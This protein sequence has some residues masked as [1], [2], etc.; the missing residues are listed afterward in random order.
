[1][2]ADLA[3]AQPAAEA[4]PVS[5]PTSFVPVAEIP[6]RAQAMNARLRELD[7]EVE[8]TPLETHVLEELARLAK[9]IEP[10]VGPIMDNLAS[11]PALA[12]LEHWHQRWKKLARQLTSLESQLSARA[13]MLDAEARRLGESAQLWTR[14]RDIARA[15]GAPDG[16]LEDAG[17]TIAATE[18]VAEAFSAQ[19]NEVL[20]LQS[21]V[22][23]L[24]ETVESTLSSMDVARERVLQSILVRDQPPLW[25]TAFRSGEPSGAADDLE[26]WFTDT[27]AALGQ[28][29]S[30][31][32]DRLWLHGFVGL[33]LIWLVYRSRR[34]MVRNTQPE[35]DG[36]ELVRD[37]ARQAFE[38]PVAGGLVLALL[39]TSW[40]HPR[41]PSVLQDLSEILLVIPVILV[42]R[43]LVGESLRLP[44]YALA[45][46]FLADQLREV[47]SDSG[48]LDRGFLLTEMA[49]AA[50]GL[51]WMLR[52]ARLDRVPPEMVASRWLRLAGGWL[53][54]ALAVTLFSLVAGSAGYMRIATLLGDA[55]LGSAYA[56][57]FLYAVVRVS[58]GVVGGLLRSNRLRRLHMV[59]RHA[60]QIADRTATGLRIVAVAS[61]AWWVLGMLAV[62][63]PLGSLGNDLLEAP[64]GYG[65]VTFSLGG[66]LA[67]GITLLAAWWISRTINF[68]LAEE[69]YPRVTLPRGVP[70]ALST[71]GRYAILLGGFV[72]AVGALGF[73]LD[74]VTIL[75]GA[76]G[77]GIGFGLQ[78]VVNNFVSGLIL[79]FERPVQVEDRVELVEVSGVVKRIGIRATTVRTWDGADVIVPNGTLIS[80]RV[81][82]WTL[83]DRLRRII[84]PVGVA[85]GNDPHRV[86][87]VL[88][89]VPPA[90][91]RIC[92]E[93]APMILFAGF[94]ESSLD[95]EVRVWTDQREDWIAVRSDVAMAVHDAL[96]AA[97]IE[98]PFPQRDLNVRALPPELQSLI[99]P[100]ANPP[101]LR[102]PLNPPENPP[103]APSDE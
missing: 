44:L 20:I 26:R 95:F 59:R 2:A 45:G 4:L 12:D 11:A 82:N 66:L 1:M 16:I 46:F 55:V 30:Q 29:A 79:L 65:A 91:H 21:Q 40:F 67:F 71:L 19:R 101:K 87:Q 97:G 17:L 41:A 98:I 7:Y 93:P 56:A 50:G 31:H 61:W 64:I 18:S 96:V 39:A 86:L 76:F 14:T 90:D 68:V 88:G 92:H 24:L 85:Y 9:E 22:V 10:Q 25:R 57:L 103:D 33:A 53:R 102:S 81:I 23:D 28:Y 42:L 3:V 34:A 94:G 58:E 63:A 13:A 69:V 80:D 5:P 62:R 27:R 15:E 72:I 43:P 100:R 6:S 8:T 36:A 47:S 73:D 78:N 60:N 89:E 84:I 54:G 74:R 32:P 48:L 49:V 83:A 75:L 77:V 38:S 99:N 70:F 51:G 35:G 37:A 52:G